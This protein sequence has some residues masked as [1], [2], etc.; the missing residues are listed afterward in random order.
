MVT[1]S[2][3]G[4]RTTRGHRVAGHGLELRL[5]RLQSVG[6]VLGVDEQPVE[7]AAGADLG[8]QGASAADPHAD[9]GAIRLVESL[10]L[11]VGSSF[12]R[13]GT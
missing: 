12:I 5:Q 6:G 3:D 7:A 10:S 13:S 2:L 1:G 9:E 4:V 8:D 11:K